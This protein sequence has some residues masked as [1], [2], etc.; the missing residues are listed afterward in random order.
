VEPELFP[1]LRKYGV[2]F[3][4]FNPLAGGYL[5]SRYTR[6]MLSGDKGIEDGSRFDQK[7]RQGQNYRRR[8]WNETYFDALDIL[9]PVGLLLIL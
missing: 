8:Y 2:A 4:A 9:R 1:C 3:Y 6:E 5:T 7:K